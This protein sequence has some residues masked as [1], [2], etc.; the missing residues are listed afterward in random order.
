M[1]CYLLS[2]QIHF[3]RSD[4]NLECSMEPAGSQE[5]IVWDSTNRGLSEQSFRTK[6]GFVIF[7]DSKDF[8]S[9]NNLKQ[10]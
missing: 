4:P 7:L 6:T 10:K 2:E 3:L 1:E 9:K 8:L 5:S